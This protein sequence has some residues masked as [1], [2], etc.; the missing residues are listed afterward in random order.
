MD[1]SRRCTATARRTGQRCGRSAILGGN[2]C[3]TH[4]GSIGRVKR[5]AAERLAENE[6][7]AMVARMTI[8]PVTD[9]IAELKALAGRALAWEKTFDQ[10]RQELAEFRYRDERSGEQIRAE[11]LLVERGMD[12]CLAIL[13]AVAKLALDER[14]VKLEEAKAALVE[15]LVLGVFTDLGLT[16]GADV[17]GGGVTLDDV[18]GQSLRDRFDP[19]REAGRTDPAAWS[20]T[21]STVTPGP[22]RSRSCSPSRTT[23][24]P[25]SRPVTAPASPR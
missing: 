17:R 21:A 20:A 23:N 13:T 14:L 11:I 2:V 8:E 15:Q 24:A 19:A 5:R 3:A 25:P 1:P 10:K 6:A 22:S 18:F 4:G 16:P 12:R 7:T 9:P